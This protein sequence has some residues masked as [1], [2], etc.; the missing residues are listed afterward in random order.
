MCGKP[1]AKMA[2]WALVLCLGASRADADATIAPTVLDL[3][4]D[5]KRVAR[6]LKVKNC[7]GQEISCRLLLSAFE[8]IGA[9]ASSET[10]PEGIRAL[11]ALKANPLEFTLAPGS[12]QDVTLTLTRDARCRAGRYKATVAVRTATG[13][14]LDVRTVIAVAVQPTIA[15]DVEAA[16]VEAEKHGDRVSA[17][18]RFLVDANVPTVQFYAAASALFYRETLPAPAQVLEI[19]L[20]MPR[21]AEIVPSNA[22]SEGGSQ[23]RVSYLDRYVRIGTYPARP[24]ESVAFTSREGDFF[25]QTVFVSVFWTQQDSRKPAGLYSG[26]ISLT[27]LVMPDF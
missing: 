13:A 21:G 22:A 3:T 25:S 26:R 2:A 16:A 24:T 27:G 1:V 19:P 11:P 10:G 15:I 12:H 6:V 9:K 7:G 23:G 18:A 4:L 20:D 14:E 8:R 5:K 17:M